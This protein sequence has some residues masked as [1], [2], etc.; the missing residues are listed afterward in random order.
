MSEQNRLM[1]VYG[2][3][4]EVAMEALPVPRMTGS[5]SNTTSCPE[6]VDAA[7][8]PCLQ[9]DSAL[10]NAIWD[11]GGGYSTCFVNH[12]FGSKGTMRRVFHLVVESRGKDAIR[13]RLHPFVLRTHPDLADDITENIMLSKGNADLLRLLD[14]DPEELRE[15]IREYAHVLESIR[16]MEGS[17]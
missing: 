17:Q 11:R 12:Y 2:T 14:G 16:N 1:Y 3:I 15:K 9:D 7:H 5:K 8:A 10:A 4:P 13:D 6:I